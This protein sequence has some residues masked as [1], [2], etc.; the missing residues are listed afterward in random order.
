MR[1]RFLKFGELIKCLE[2]WSSLLVLRSMRE[3]RR[4]RSIPRRGN[5]EGF[6]IGS[7]YDEVG[8]LR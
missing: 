7:D 2:M 4:E 6:Y 5:G 1:D 3:R 8:C